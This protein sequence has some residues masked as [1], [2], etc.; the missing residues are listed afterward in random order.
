MP[1]E[2]AFNLLR[3]GDGGLHEVVVAFFARGIQAAVAVW[4]ARL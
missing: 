1:S 3:G 4:D 2:F